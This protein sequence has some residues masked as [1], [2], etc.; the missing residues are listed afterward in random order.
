M[1]LLQ[2][3]G[4]SAETGIH[5]VCVSLCVR[6]LYRDWERE[7]ERALLSPKR[8][9]NC[10]SIF[11]FWTSLHIFVLLHPHSSHQQM[12]LVLPSKRSHKLTASTPTP[13]TLIK[14]T[15]ILYLTLTPASSQ[16][17]LHRSAR[18]FLLKL[19]SCPMLI[20][21]ALSCLLP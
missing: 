12:L 5:A 7:R 2:W 6:V 14:D 19:R 18:L 4:C 15:I 8:C 17:L 3:L 20:S 10:F 13:T 1:E 9:P 21:Q 11:A 16:F